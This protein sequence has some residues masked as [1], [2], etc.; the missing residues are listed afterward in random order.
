MFPHYWT[1]F[2]KSHELVDKS[3]S[4]TEDEDMSG[5]GAEVEFLTE[6]QS[7]DELENCWPGIGV[8]KDGFVPIASCKIGT[9]D[10]YYINSNDGSNG[11]LYR[12]YHDAVGTDGYDPDAALDIVLKHYESILLYVSP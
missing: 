7:N 4:L 10:Y 8:A 2:V 1:E 3:A 9:G 5:V 12:I 6:D 11:P